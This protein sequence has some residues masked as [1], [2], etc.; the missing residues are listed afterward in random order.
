M[1][2][3]KVENLTPLGKGVAHKIKPPKESRRLIDMCEKFVE[4]YKT[5]VTTQR[6]YKGVLKNHNMQGLTKNI[7]LYTKDEIQTFFNALSHFKK[8]ANYCWFI[9]KAVF[10]DAL[11][12]GII[13]RNVIANMKS[14]AKNSKRR[15]WINLAG[16][17]LIRDNLSKCKIADELLFY[18]LTGARCDEAF[19]V[20]P[21]WEKRQVFI[22]G[23]KTDSAPRYVKLS[24]KACDYFAPRWAGMFKYQPHYYSKNTTPFLKSLGIL[25][26]SL[27]SLRHCFSTNLYYLGTDVKRHQYL[28][29]HK[30]SKITLDTYTS[31]DPSI[32]KDDV[33]AVWADWY[34]DEF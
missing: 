1:R 21:N 13:K 19:H 17:K 9:I 14:P 3:Y 34:P 30:D 6:S 33:L 8:M 28:M 11:A 7:E 27:H 10:A 15:E 5:G 32:T 24:Q 20:A 31:F 2:Q 26:K 25:E 16:Q 18:I 4:L 23:T 22:D 29:G 12:A